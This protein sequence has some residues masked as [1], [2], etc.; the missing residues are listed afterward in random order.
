MAIL[1]VGVV[2]LLNTE[3]TVDNVTTLPGKLTSG[4]AANFLLTLLV[5]FSESSWHTGFGLDNKQN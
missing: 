3:V 5:S 1:K 2:L 4:G